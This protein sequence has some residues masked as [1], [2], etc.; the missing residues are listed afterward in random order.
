MS[1]VGALDKT[2][3]FA[4]F[5]E[6]LQTNEGFLLPEARK[7]LARHNIEAVGT[8]DIGTAA[9]YDYEDFAPSGPIVSLTNPLAWGA[10]GDGVTDDTVAIQTMLSS[11]YHVID[12][13][14]EDFNYLITD[15]LVVTQPFR[16]WV[17]SA[18]RSE[19]RRVGKEC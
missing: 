3:H 14:N 15:T 18:K 17:G 7:A 11:N 10:K 4:E 9:N 12:W 13:L 19:E 2:K 16:C 8:G 1:L 6:L 5:S